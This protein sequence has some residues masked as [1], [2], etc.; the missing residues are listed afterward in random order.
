MGECEPFFRRGSPWPHLS[1]TESQAI[2]KRNFG[3]QSSLHLGSQ[4]FMKIYFQDMILNRPA[5]FANLVFCEYCDGE[6]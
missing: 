2:Q 3:R 6:F 1:A 4:G 5:Y